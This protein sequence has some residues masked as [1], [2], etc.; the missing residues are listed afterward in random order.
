MKKYTKK[1]LS[2]TPN[3][4]DLWHGIGGHFD[5]LT[6]ILAE[7]IDNSISNFAKNKDTSQAVRIDFKKKN[8]AYEITIEDTGTGIKNLEPVMR[9]GDKSV[10]ETPLNEHGFGLKH[11][12]ASANF[13]NDD[14][15]ICTRTKEDIKNGF[16]RLVEAPY[17]YEI[18][19]KKI[20][21][22]WQGHFNETGTIIKFVVSDSMFETLQKG[23]RGRTATFGRSL[24][25]LSED[26]G[27]IYAGV[28]KN[29]KVTIQIAAET[30]GF[31]E[32]VAVISPDWAGF[33]EPK[34]GQTKLDLG[35]GRIDVEYK[36]GEMNESAYKKYYKRN[37]ATQGVEIRINGRLILS[38]I[39]TEIW[40]LER[41]N[42]YNHFLV[43]INLISED[44]LKL[45]KTR[46]SKN[47]IRSGDERLEALF[48]WVREV[49]PEPEKKMAGAVNERELVD[50]LAKQK[51]M[52]I[53]AP[54]KRVDV[55]FE[56]FKQLG[57]PVPVDL[58]VFDGK[59]VV[60]YEAKRDAATILN[61]Y[62]LVM[63]WDGLV[64]DGMYPNEGILIAS[65]IS[66]GVKAMLE[67]FNSRQDSKG[68]NYCLK[69]KT[70]KDEGVIYPK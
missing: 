24:E 29:G 38:N 30:E 65:E 53:R 68:K 69:S 26:L 54:E 2:I 7:F 11:A 59:E 63:Y 50:E 3:A 58:Y 43:Q 15:S 35:G 57:A 20:T 64:Y 17:S 31:N 10:S 13:N 66:D 41:H 9:L 48:K 19:Q 67:Y 36:F 28:I 33:Y 62:Q 8:K 1:I 18:T 51:K 12:L 32:T 44:I 37:L 16:Y 39:F 55:E 70:W 21:S 49:H 22:P 34:N 47:G 56:V 27:Y 45:P 23:I 6:Q 14:W 4:Q 60:I 25:Y 52:H 61:V 46:T 5:S 40:P 42:S